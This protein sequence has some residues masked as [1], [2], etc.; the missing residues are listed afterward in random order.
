[1]ADDDE[2]HLRERV[3]TLRGCHLPVARSEINLLVSGILDKW[4]IAQRGAIGVPLVGQH[5]LLVL[6]AEELR[7]RRLEPAAAELI[8]AR[9]R[10]LADPTRLLVADAL[11]REGRRKAAVRLEDNA[12]IRLTV[13]SAARGQS[14][15]QQRDGDREACHA[16]TSPRINA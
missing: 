3:V 8:A 14:D 15:H 11:A 9:M 1:V 7:T 12:V 5:H 4:L 6:R 2:R 16:S 10:A 13:A